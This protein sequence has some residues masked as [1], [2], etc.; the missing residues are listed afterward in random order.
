MDQSKVAHYQNQNV[1]FDVDFRATSKVFLG[2]VSAK[3]GYENLL[4]DRP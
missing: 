2:T 3:K 1:R 4:A